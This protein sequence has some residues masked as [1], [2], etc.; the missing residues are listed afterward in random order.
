MNPVPVHRVPFIAALAACL[1][2]A[3][4]AGVDMFGPPPDGRGAV[5]TPDGRPLPPQAA[6]D[7]IAIGKSSKADV[8]SALGQAIAIPFDSGYE[9]WVYR[10]PGA[11]KTPRT[12]S[13]LVVLFDPSGTAS[14]LR[15]R[16]GYAPR[17]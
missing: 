15:L 3:G 17:D 8:L 7:T 9:V 2:M 16:P 12:A 4:C 11:D 6:M 5:R 13:E 1:C 10:W 14:K